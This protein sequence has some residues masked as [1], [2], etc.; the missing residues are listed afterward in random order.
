[1]RVLTSA[2]RHDPLD[3][4]IGGKRDNDM[5]LFYEGRRYVQSDKQLPL[6]DVVFTVTSWG[7]WKRLYPRSLLYSGPI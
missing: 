6:A 3:L 4:R 1:M 7:E 5:L 2:N